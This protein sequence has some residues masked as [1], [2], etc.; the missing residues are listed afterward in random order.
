MESLYGL[1]LITY[2]DFFLAW[3]A[4]SGPKLPPY[5]HTTRLSLF[6]FIRASRAGVLVF[7]Q[8]EDIATYIRKGANGCVGKGGQDTVQA[9][10]RE[11]SRFFQE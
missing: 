8:E 1:S 4:R 9:M 10:G 5:T 6:F 2:T 3:R 7:F 11:Y